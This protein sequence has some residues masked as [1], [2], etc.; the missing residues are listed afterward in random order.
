MTR[1]IKLLSLIV[2][3]SC[4]VACGDDSSDSESGSGSPVSMNEN[5]GSS[6][7]LQS[8][9]VPG[10]ANIYAATLDALPEMS[11]GAG[12]LPP[13]INFIARPGQVMTVSNT[14]GETNC[15]SGS[16]SD[17]PDGVNSASATNLNSF[18]DISGIVHPSRTMFLTAVFTNG[19][20]S[21]ELP[22]ASLDYNDIDSETTVE[23]FPE[24]NQVFYVGDGLTTD[25]TVQSF[26][27]PESATAVSFGVADG[28]SFSGEPG[29]YDDNTGEWQVSFRI[30]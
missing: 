7:Q 12:V 6:G 9:L 16:P 11:G 13:S 4:L 10:Q 19:R 23:F 22:P 15:C 1:T 18:Q 24:L 26:F 14:S 21:A 27:V 28:F 17:P 25:G 29:F 5:T 30:D 3:T 2:V 8:I 20:N